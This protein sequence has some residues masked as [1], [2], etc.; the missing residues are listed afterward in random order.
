MGKGRGSEGSVMKIKAVCHT[1]G[2][3]LDIDEINHVFMENG[4]TYNF[5]SSECLVVFLEEGEEDNE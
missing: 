5:C 3:I 4:F 1:C 2:E